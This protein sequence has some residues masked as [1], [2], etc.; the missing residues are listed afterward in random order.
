M[1]LFI[2]SRYVYIPS[3][4]NFNSFSRKTLPHRDKEQY[5][6]SLVNSITKLQ[7]KYLTRYNRKNTEGEALAH[8]IILLTLHSKVSYV[9]AKKRQIHRLTAFC[10]KFQT[11]AMLQ[12]KS[13]SRLPIQ[14][15]LFTPLVVCVDKKYVPNNI[16]NYIRNNVHSKNKKLFLQQKL[17][18]NYITFDNINWNAHGSAIRK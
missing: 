1:Q 14:T 2:S 18:I 15:H 4:T 16:V 5:T 7:K 11:N 9:A 13:E 10:L 12:A 3:G 17:Q 6:T 8:I